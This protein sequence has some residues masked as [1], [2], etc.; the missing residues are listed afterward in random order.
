MIIS[1]GVN[2]KHWR[3]KTLKEELRY[4]EYMPY[5]KTDKLEALKKELKK[6]QTNWSK[7][8][9]VLYE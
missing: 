8:A 6:R 2:I 4:L 9:L 5:G 7:M 1:K 3:I